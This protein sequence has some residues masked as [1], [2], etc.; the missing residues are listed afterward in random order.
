M[1]AKLKREK[2]SVELYEVLKVLVSQL[3]PTHLPPYG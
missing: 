3:Y 2:C 1:K